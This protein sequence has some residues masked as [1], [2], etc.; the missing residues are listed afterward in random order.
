MKLKT[1][2][3]EKGKKTFAQKCVWCHV[4]EMGGKLKDGP[5]LPRL[6]GQKMG[7]TTAF[8]YTDALESRGIAWEMTQAWSQCLEKHP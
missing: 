1:S 8:S 4:V 5:N 2:D 6:P 7:Q 3:V